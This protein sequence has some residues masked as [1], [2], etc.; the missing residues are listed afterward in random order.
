MRAER[1]AVRVLASKAQPFWAAH[2]IPVIVWKKDGLQNFLE[3][4][5]TALCA[6][7]R[8]EWETLDENAAFAARDSFQKLGENVIVRALGGTAAPG[9]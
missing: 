8:G 3:K 2:P 4:N 1:P 5:P 7:R 9:K 6:L